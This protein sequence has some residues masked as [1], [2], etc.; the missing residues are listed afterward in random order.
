MQCP[1]C[2][3]KLLRLRAKLSDGVKEIWIHPETIKECVYKDKD[4]VKVSVEVIDEFLCSK[5]QELMQKEALE[6]Q[7]S[8]IAVIDKGTEQSEVKN[9]PIFTNF[10]T[11][12][13]YKLAWVYR[14][15]EVI[16]TMIDKELKN[17]GITE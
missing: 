7:P 9:Q 16:K 5:F 2:K 10:N 4:A 13:L 3:E 14:E 12:E 17:R 8:E 11:T 1:Q 15:Q 6:E